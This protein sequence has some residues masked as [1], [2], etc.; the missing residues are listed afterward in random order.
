[1]LDRILEY[2]KAVRICYGQSQEVDLQLRNTSA[3]ECHVAQRVLECRMP[4]METFVLNQG[5]ESWPLSDNISSCVTLTGKVTKISEDA[6][7][8]DG[9]VEPGTFNYKLGMYLRDA[10][11]G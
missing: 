11:T 4:I 3:T 1:M 8:T 10:V 7:S 2:R 9:S 6:L 5:K